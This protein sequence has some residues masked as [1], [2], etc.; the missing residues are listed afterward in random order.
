MLKLGRARPIE[1]HE[2]E[3]EIERIFHEIRSTLRVT[4]VDLSFR[5]WA[6]FDRV[7]PAIWEALR[8]NLETRAFEHGA[9][10]LRAES[11]ESAALLGKVRAFSTVSLGPSQRYQLQKALDLYHYLNPKLLLLTSAL[12]QSLKGEGIGGREIVPGECELI[13]RG[14]PA[15]MAP[16][17]MEPEEPRDREARRIFA[18]VGRT[19]DSSWI[20]SEYRAIALWPEYLKAAWRDLK[21]IVRTER[22]RSASEDLRARAREMARGLP[23]PVPLSSA[24]LEELG[25]DAESIFDTTASF[26]RLL[27]PLLLNVALLQLE[28]QTVEEVSVSPYPAAVRRPPLEEEMVE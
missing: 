7:L 20:H 27:P 2:A 11:V 10:R 18:D 12:V 17:E 15:G 3:G 14:A 4:G 13:E 22:Y 19:L 25:A 24:H 8:P 23:Y 6:A 1:E 5:V 26:E 28:R 21:P 9:D 16:M